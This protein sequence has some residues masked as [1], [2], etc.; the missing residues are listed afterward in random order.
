[1]LGW[2]A[3]GR[4][5]RAL[6]RSG[7]PGVLDRSGKGKAEPHAAR[8]KSIQVVRAFQKLRSLSKNLRR[9]KRGSPSCVFGWAGK[10]LA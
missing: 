5:G 1:V 9:K 8:S 3:V 4:R 6:N 10:E 7:D 2:A